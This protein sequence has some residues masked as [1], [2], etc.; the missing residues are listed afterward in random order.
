MIGEVLTFLRGRL[1]GYI[2]V[3]LGVVPGES[4]PDRVVLL[5]G[6]KMDPIEFPLGAVTALLI[7]IEQEKLQPA[8]DP[9]YRM[10][11]DGK[12]ERVHPEIRMNL[13]VLF[14]AHFK[15]YEQG[16]SYLSLIIQYFQNHRLLSHDNAPE[17]SDRIEK[18]TLELVT[19][20]FSEQ[21]EVWNALRTTYHPSVMYRVRMVVFEDDESISGPPIGERVIR[22]TQ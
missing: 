7:N 3:R 17:L 19:L 6:E 22:T 4:N 2:S 12:S 10:L 14:V 21:N 5:D 18:L 15:Q 11:A 16:L 20:P 13:Y 9:Y 8:P 1:N